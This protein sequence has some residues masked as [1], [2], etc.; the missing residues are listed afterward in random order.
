MTPHPLESGERR[1]DMNMTALVVTGSPAGDRPRGNRFRRNPRGAS[2]SFGCWSMRLAP[3][4]DSLSEAPL[5]F[6]A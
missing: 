3:R 5:I 1:P 4:F 6:P 2:V